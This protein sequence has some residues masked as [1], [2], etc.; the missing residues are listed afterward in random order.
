MTRQGNIRPATTGD[1]EEIKRLALDNGMFEIDQLDDFEEMMAG[2]F[3]GTLADHS[4]IVLEDE[5]DDVAGAAY[6]GPEPFAD[7]MWNLY[8]IAARPSQH[9]SG[10]G[11]ALITHVEEVLRGKGDQSARVLIVETSSLSGYDQ[12]RAFYR[13][14]G[15]A[16]EARI[17][18]FYGPGDDK[19]VFWKAL[20]PTP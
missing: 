16:E 7:R 11:Q 13:K 12:A 10:I 3:D 4:W 15:Y 20:T 5:H 8:F 9:R 19:I 6:Y 17:R 18:E 14:Q 1:A 2:S